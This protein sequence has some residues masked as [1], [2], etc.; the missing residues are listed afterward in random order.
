M[1]RADFL[2]AQRWFDPL[3][4]DAW[5]C[6]GAEPLFAG[7]V[8]F[9]ALTAPGAGTS[10]LDFAAPLLGSRTQS[11]CQLALRHPPRVGSKRPLGDTE[12]PSSSGVAAGAGA[13]L[14]VRVEAA[15]CE[16]VHGRILHPQIDQLVDNFEEDRPTPRVPC[17]SLRFG[18]VWMVLLPDAETP[19]PAAVES[20]R[21]T[22]QRMMQVARER[23]RQTESPLA[24]P[25]CRA[26]ASSSLPPRRLA[27]RQALRPE[28]ASGV[29]SSS[30]SPSPSSP[31]RP[32]VPTARRVG[33]W[34]GFLRC[35]QALVGRLRQG[36]PGDDDDDDAARAAA[37][38]EDELL[39]ALPRR[40]AGA[41]APAAEAEAARAER[42]ARYRQ[43][44]E[45]FLRCA[46]RHLLKEAT[47][48]GVEGGGGG[49]AEGGD[50]VSSAA[51]ASAALRAARDGLET[52]YRAMLDAEALP[53]RT[54]PPPGPVA[55]STYESLAR[56]R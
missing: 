52:S 6:A 40:Y 8:S 19:I 18:S 4:A 55:P 42:D 22:T 56:Q 54:A 50:G 9:E 7:V 35:T 31:P 48:G 11:R 24:T 29:P 16:P 12:P 23:E 46:V 39:A 3:A 5:P 51:S 34:H 32:R 30:P 44:E 33:H 27:P 43:H 20:L 21:N 26:R 49:G 38:A 14:L 28:S 2:R 15:G 1:Q 45:Q 41:M 10:P 17:L 47:P 36:A 25:P 13:A 53:S 37:A